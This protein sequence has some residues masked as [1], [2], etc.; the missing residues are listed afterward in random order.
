MNI[1]ERNLFNFGSKLAAAFLL[2]VFN[3]VR[4]PLCA[5]LL[6]APFFAAGQAMEAWL[7]DVAMNW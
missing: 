1:S 5:V 3:R 2:G 7:C 4:I 6:S